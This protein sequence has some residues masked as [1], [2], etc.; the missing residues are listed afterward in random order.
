ME[1]SQLPVLL[2][3]AFGL[4]LVHSLDADHVMAVTNLATGR[5]ELKST[6]QFCLR[7]AIGHGLIL[8]IVGVLVFIVGIHLPES[9]SQ[10]AEI[11][12]ASILILL[13]IY[14]LYEVLYRR[15]HIHFHQHDDM[16]QHAHW[17]S[18]ATHSSH[19][20]KHTAMFIGMLH[21]LAGSAPLLALIPLGITQQPLHGFLY[22]VIFSLGVIVS[23]L[24]F[25][26]VLGYVS[27]HIVCYSTKL[28]RYLRIIL[29]LG[30]MMVGTLVLIGKLA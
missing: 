7:W 6:I 8:F 27:R 19:R 12:V 16:P 4:G 24:V 18:H 13:G 25:G 14:V 30:A 26:G 5:V 15:I 22:L 20:H 11:M 10:Y 28:F 17:H 23:M 21:G 9:V 2:T 29:G 1:L 3:L